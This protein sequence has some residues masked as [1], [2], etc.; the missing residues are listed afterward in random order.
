MKNWEYISK[1][2]LIG[3]RIHIKPRQKNFRYK[4][5][6]KCSQLFP[7]NL[8]ET[9]ELANKAGLSILYFDIDEGFPLFDTQWFC[10]GRQLC[11]DAN[12]TERM[13]EYIKGG[14]R[15]SKE[16]LLSIAISMGY[17]VEEIQ[18]LMKTCGYVLSDSIPAD[19]VVLYY[20]INN[21]VV[22][23]TSLVWQINTILEE[24]ELELLGTKFY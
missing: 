17:R 5:I 1:R 7:L 14:M 21:D 11:H 23:G 12:I 16:T 18:K 9:E 6:L 13:L 3:L 2:Y 15:P 10:S 8:E 24:L 4:F 19:R 22:G 20:L